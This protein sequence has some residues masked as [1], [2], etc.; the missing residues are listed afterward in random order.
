MREIAVFKPGYSCMQ[1]EEKQRP[2]AYYADGL[3]DRRQSSFRNKRL[4]L[5]C[6]FLSE[7][8]GAGEFAAG[9]PAAD[10]AAPDGQ[11]LEKCLGV[12]HEV[13]LC[14]PLSETVFP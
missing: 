13:L 10:G 3:S 8:R 9:G 2:S 4:K 11:R 1:H 5:L 12:Y 7:S 14:T 6:R